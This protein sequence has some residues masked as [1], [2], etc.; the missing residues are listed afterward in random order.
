[1][2]GTI[3]KRIKSTIATE[4]KQSTI[5]RVFEALQ[6]NICPRRAL[7]ARFS[8]FT[9]MDGP[10]R[11]YHASLTNV[12]MGLFIEINSI[13]ATDNWNLNITIVTERIAHLAMILHAYALSPKPILQVLCFVA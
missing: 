5:L 3:R 9:L 1:M 13:T 8:L 10:A 7:T 2:T 6:C 11:I 4:K 12:T